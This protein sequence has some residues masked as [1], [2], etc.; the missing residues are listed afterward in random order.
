M[1]RF[2]GRLDAAESSARMLVAQKMYGPHHG[3]VRSTVSFGG[4]ASSTVSGKFSLAADG[5][6]AE[7]RVILKVLRLAGL[8]NTSWPHPAWS[9]WS[10]NAHDHCIAFSAA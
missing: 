9:N 3:L 8:A 1:W 4:C 7:S 6:Q 2:D 10:G 5:L